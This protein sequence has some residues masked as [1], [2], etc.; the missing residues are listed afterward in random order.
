VSRRWF[1]LAVALT[2]LTAEIVLGILQI[3]V[4][5]HNS[6]KWSTLTFAVPPGVAFALAG[7]VAVWR[8]PGNRTGIYL[9]AV[10]Y[11]WFIG[12]LSDSNVDG[13]FTAAFVLQS[14]AFI[15]FILLI[16]SFPTGRLQTR[17]Q[18]IYIVVAS[19]VIIAAPL[20]VLLVDRTPEPS[21]DNGCRESVIALV[22]SQ[23]ASDAVNVAT[24]LVG[25]FLI[26]VAGILMVARWRA[27][28]PAHRNALRLVLTTSGI[29]IGALLVLNAF[30]AVFG[31]DSGAISPLFLLAFTAVPVSFLVGLLRTR[32][33]RSSVAA[34]V[35]E[36]GHGA[37][38]EAALARVLGDPT[39]E[40][41]Y[42]T[43]QQGWIDAEGRTALDPQ[44]QLGRSTTQVM[45][46]GG[47]IAT[48]VH[49]PSLGEE[50]ELVDAVT[51]AASLSLQNERLDA[52]LRA[53]SKLTETIADTVPSLLVSVDLDGRL[54]T[55][56]GAAVRAVGLESGAE[57]VGMPFWDVFIAPAE[58]TAMIERFMAAAPAFERASYENTFTNAHGDRIVIA[59]ESAPLM[60]ERGRVTGIVAGGLDI[61]ER[62]QREIELARERD[63][64]LRQEA[65]VRASRSRIVQAGDD[66]RQRLERNLHD[67]AQQRLVSLSISLRLIES[68]LDTDVAVAAR[69]LAGAREEL[70][71]AL[72]ELRELAR[73][74]HPAILSD[75]GLIPALESLAARLP[76]DVEIVAPELELPEAIEAAL[77]YVVAESLTNV[78]RYAEVDR[79]SVTFER[80][81]LA[82]VVEVVD[83]GAGGADSTQGTGLRGLGDRVSALDGSFHVESPRGGG[84]RIRAEIPLATP[85]ST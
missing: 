66:A 24:N 36:L 72:D 43:D 51:A 62:K 3:V 45:G 69:M 44:T 20:L 74:I 47:I 9:G 82:V 14:L 70:S 27:A 67:G 75:R 5:D 57:L 10:G 68:K 37:P 46:D 49:D 22:D 2:V 18:R 65:E 38:V 17:A 25:I 4:G 1:L 50:P 30:S 34:L 83:V 60:D 52:A 39:L 41:V 76:V 21:C 28:S 11:L 81:D 54:V 31:G 7:V 15:P 19:V 84:T 42:R 58:R 61:T 71:E 77:Y 59:W 40:V 48:L 13:I 12:A 16:L 6:S 26:V 63:L 8:R 23:R 56:N 64:R 73:G 80:D 35:V 78:V 33:A 53:Q 29:A 32:L 55:A 85:V 79:V